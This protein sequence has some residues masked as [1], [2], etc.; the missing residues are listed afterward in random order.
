MSWLC[1]QGLKILSRNYRGPKGGE[2]DIIARDGKL[3]LF[4]EVKTRTAGQSSRPLN[5]VNREKQSLIERGARHWISQL[6][7]EKPAWRHDVIEVILE[8]NEKPQV[9]HVRDAF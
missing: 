8:D 1:S 5:A 3:L 7:C 4:I 9:N 2:V 6:G